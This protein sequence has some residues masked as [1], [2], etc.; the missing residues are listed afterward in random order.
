MLFSRIISCPF[1]VSGLTGYS[2]L[3]VAMGST[4]VARRAGKKQAKSPASITV[5]TTPI[6]VRGSVADTPVSWLAT[7]R[8]NCNRRELRVRTD[9]TEGKAHISEQSTHGSHSYS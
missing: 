5:S 7:K 6:R 1:Q 3:S 4:S 9:L 2:L 8:E